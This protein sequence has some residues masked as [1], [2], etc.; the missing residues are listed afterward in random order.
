MQD[1]SI[2]EEFLEAYDKYADAVFRHIFFR[3]YDR[4]LAKD[5]MQETFEKTW[6]YISKGNGVENMKAFL[7]RVAKNLLVSNVRKHKEQSLDVL[8]DGGFTPVGVNAEDWKISIDCNILLNYVDKLPK[9]YSEIIKLRYL[10]ELSPGEISKIIKKSE[11]AVSVRI[12]R[13]LQKLKKTTK[14]LK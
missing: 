1:K 9:E 14:H 13:A 3:L 6:E 10:D 4:E 7:F 12:N 2:Q 5:I 8:M 11:N